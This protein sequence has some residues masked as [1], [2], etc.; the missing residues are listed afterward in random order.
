M[1]KHALL[2]LLVLT[3]CATTAP[4]TTPAPAA[5]AVAQPCNPATA[6]VNAV[7]WTRSAAEYHASA[8]QTYAAARRQLDAALADRT[9]AGAEEEK[10]EDPSQPPAVILD[11]D[12]TSLDNSEYEMRVIRIGKTYDEAMWDQWVSEAAATAVPGAKEFLEYAKSRGVTPFYITNRDENPEG[13]GTRRNL[14]RLEFPMTAD[15]V[16]MRGGRPEWKSDKSG[17]RAHVAATHRVLLLVGDDLN[18]FVNARE[19]SKAERDAIIGRTAALWG[20]RWFMLPNPMYGSWE[21]AATGGE[22][23]PCE[24]LQKKVDALR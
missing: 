8:L 5:A 21:R 14:E 11:L 9:W 19:K 22:G 13:P 7:L 12:E 24:Q 6:L 16:L 23:T 18:D 10:N 1:R 17:R 20:T 3:G 2:V 15:A 4:T